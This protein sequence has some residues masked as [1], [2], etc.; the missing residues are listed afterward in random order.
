[1][2]SIEYTWYGSGNI[3]FKVY[4]PNRSIYETVHTLT[5]A[6]SQ[7]EPSLTAPN[8]FLQW[9]LAS[10]GSTTAKKMRIC[11]GFGATQG[12][13]NLKYP[14]YGVSS[15]KSIA[16]NTETVLMAIKNTEQMNGYSNQSEVL[17]QRLTVSTNGDKPVKVKVIINPTSLS[18]NILTDY[19]KWER[20]DDQS[21]T[22]YDT[23]SSTYT[24]GHV[25]DVFQVHEKD[26][27]YLDLKQREYQ[28]HQNNI[29]LFV[30]ESRAVS[31]IDMAVSIL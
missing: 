27:L 24:G 4:N 10:L 30:A 7:S 15:N 3:R 12:K 14:V 2:Y 31:E 22:L 5:F 29:L 6:N 1:M 8:M 26:S 19:K 25:L 17:V 18:Q 16:A 11:G 20:S 9:G 13:I 28:I 21:I 23:M